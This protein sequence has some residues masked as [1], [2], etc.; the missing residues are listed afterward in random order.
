MSC[1]RQTSACHQMQAAAQQSSDPA[2]LKISNVLEYR[3]ATSF[4]CHCH[5]CKTSFKILADLNAPG[6]P[7]APL[8]NDNCASN[9]PTAVKHAQLCYR[10][11]KRIVM[12]CRTSQ[13][14][15]VQIHQLSK[16]SCTYTR[17]LQVMF[18]AAM[19]KRCSQ[20]KRV[21]LDK[22]FKSDSRYTRVMLSPEGCCMAYRNRMRH[23][24]CLPRVCAGTGINQSSIN[25]YK[26]AAGDL[27]TALSDV[28]NRLSASIKPNRDAALFNFGIG[29]SFELDKGQVQPIVSCQGT[30]AHMHDITHTCLSISNSSTTIRHPRCLIGHVK[31]HLSPMQAASK[32][33]DFVTLS[34]RCISTNVHAQGAC[35][36]CS[37]ACSPHAAN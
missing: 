3:H 17:L 21:Q 29:A 20:S 35:I 4:L 16:F 12:V 26:A 11:T 32:Q 30:A 36:H 28:G 37:I 23:A 15:R 8:S 2:C 5:S 22:L 7:S 33:I 6:L 13:A 25:I 27:Q 31:L 14:N 1:D 24:C 34:I 18:Q 10:L 9:N 19:H